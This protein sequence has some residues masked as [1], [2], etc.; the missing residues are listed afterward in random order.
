MDEVPRHPGA[1]PREGRRQE[2]LGTNLEAFCGR[3]GCEETPQRAAR[4]GVSRLEVC[5]HT[6]RRRNFGHGRLAL[7]EP[8]VG[9]GERL[10]R[11]GAAPAIAAMT[12]QG[13]GSTQLQEPRA[14]GAG[15]VEGA[16]QTS[17]G[18]VGDGPRRPAAVSGVGQ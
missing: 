8:R 18:L 12:S 7:R 4:G 1:R 17:L 13:H 6:L 16:P 3:N 9:C 2:E 15:D 11:F 10:P 5:Q 14:L